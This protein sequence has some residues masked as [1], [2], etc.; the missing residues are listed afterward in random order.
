MKSYAALGLIGLSGLVLSGC[1]IYPEEEYCYDDDYDCP[2]DSIC[3]SDNVCVHPPS[4]NSGGS[5]G[6]PQTGVP[7][8]YPDQCG[9]NS[10]CGSDGYCHPGDC[11][12]W[13]CVSGYQCAVVD[14]AYVCVKN[15]KP[16]GGAGSGGSGAGGSA[17]SIDGGVAGSAGSE[18]GGP[19]GS[20]GQAGSAGEAGAAGAPD[21]GKTIYCGNPDDCP[22]GQSC[23]PSG[24]CQVGSCTT[25]GCIEGYVCSNAAC[26]PSNPAACIGDT[27]CSSLGAAYKCVNGV[28]TGADQLCSDKTQC[29]GGNLDQSKCVDGKCVEA[30]T[31]DAGAS[32]TYGYA[33][34]PALGIC[35]PAGNGCS[36]TEDCNSLALVCVDGA[37]VARCLPGGT[38]PEGQVCVANGCVPDQKPQ[39]DCTVDGVQDVCAV[40]SICLH[41]HCYISC[42]SPNQLACDN[43]PP[44]LNVCKTVTTSSGQHPICGSNANLGSECDPTAGTSCSGGKVCIDGF[45]K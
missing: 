16:D 32:C 7:C 13:Q 45:C 24:T 40:T 15:K 37:C 20:A 17:G 44:E 38:C 23:T 6:S 3:N 11:F 43:N 10:V 21:A 39:F 33:C 5:A 19:A 14:D 2:S 35:V 28:C 30:C 29:P 18:D 41:H 12:F 1:P 4:P 26:V 31:A 25:L 27:D 34:D 22:A 9:P 8:A 42:A 36:I